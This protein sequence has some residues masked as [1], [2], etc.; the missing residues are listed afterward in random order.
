MPAIDD[1]VSSAL[2]RRSG[3]VNCWA[4]DLP[5]E[6]KKYIEALQ[7]REAERP[8]SVNRAQVARDLRDH[9][10]FHINISTVKRHFTKECRCVWS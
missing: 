4:V 9:F 3:G 2:H 6:A 5:P 7:Q 10:D 8:L 1:L